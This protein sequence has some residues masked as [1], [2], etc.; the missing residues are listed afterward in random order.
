MSEEWLCGAGHFHA[1]GLHC[2]ATG[3]EPPWGCPCSWCQDGASE[4]DE[5]AYWN[6]ETLGLEC[7]D[8]PE[9]SREEG[10]A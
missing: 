8:A 1:D 5:T 2:L 6:E 7:D 4:E 9:P 10:E 3:E